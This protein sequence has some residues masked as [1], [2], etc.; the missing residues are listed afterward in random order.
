MN[1]KQIRILWVGIIVVVLM[2]LFPPTVGSYAPTRPRKGYY[3]YAQPSYS[4][5]LTA[6]DMKITAGLHPVEAGFVEDNVHYKFIGVIDFMKLL[7]Q[8]F[9]VATITAGVIV[10][11]RNT[12]AKP[13]E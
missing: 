11:N 12:D 1:K 10:S 13:K 6:S 3:F 7:V 9:I 5:L 8:W 2:G 4:F